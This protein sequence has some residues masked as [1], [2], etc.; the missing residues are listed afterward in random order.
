M[1]SMF[2]IFSDYKR[3]SE[4]GNLPPDFLAATEYLDAP[5]DYAA[6]GTSG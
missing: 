4:K 1:L 2:K 3:S 5:R 6:A